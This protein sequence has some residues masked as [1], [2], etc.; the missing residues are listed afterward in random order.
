MPNSNYVGLQHCCQDMAKT[1]YLEKQIY[2]FGSRTITKSIFLFSY[3][4]LGSR[5]W[6]NVRRI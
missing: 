3:Q 1:H 5:T 4:A 2:I 6:S